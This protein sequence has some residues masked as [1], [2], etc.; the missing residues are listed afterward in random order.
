MLRVSRSL[1]IRCERIVQPALDLLEERTWSSLRIYAAGRCV[2]RWLERDTQEEM[3]SI[4]VPAFQLARWIV[5]NWWS[6]LNE[7]C[8]GET[9]P[10]PGAYGIWTTPQRHWLERHC[11][12]SAD[13]G[14]FLPRLTLWHDGYRINAHW[15]PDSENAYSTMPGQFLFGSSVRLDPRDV[16]DAL[17]EFVITVLRWLEEEPDPRVSRLQANW[18]AIANASPEEVAFCRAAGRLGLDP[19]QLS[20]WP[21]GLPELLE[22]ALSDQNPEPIVHDFLSA[23]VP[24][25]LQPLW[26]WLVNLRDSVQL[27]GTQ[28]QAYGN[29]DWH[30]HAGQAGFEAAYRLRQKINLDDDAKINQVTD[31]AHEMSLG[32]L[33]FQDYNHIPSHSIKAVVGWHKDPNPTLIGPIPPLSSSRR[34]IEA[35]ALFHAAF[36]CEHGPRLVTRAHDWDQQASRGFAAELL[37]PRQALLARLSDVDIDDRA[38]PIGRL[39]QEY[40]VSSELISRQL[41][42]ALNYGASAD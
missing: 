8:H 30:G 20:S 41:Q 28:N 33:I 2:T 38:D 18:E 9:P 26:A 24:S 21:E 12:R 14:I 7:S 40:D 36:L 17:R 23:V 4:Y 25:D 31:V 11:L 32:G 15:V 10:S 42:N 35:R 6:L 39:A 34:F 19:Y 5:A 37:A 16:E 27:Y 1:S 13:S 3:E 22:T 29:L